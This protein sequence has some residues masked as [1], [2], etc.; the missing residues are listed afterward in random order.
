MSHDLQPDSL[1][2]FL[3]DEVDLLASLGDEA[4]K[5]ALTEG[6]TTRV[7]SPGETLVRAGDRPRGLTV[8]H[9]GLLEVS[10]PGPDGRSRRLGWRGRGDVVGEAGQAFFFPAGIPPTDA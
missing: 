10:A 3:L 4:A 8:V 2:G 6:F 7:L 1:K 5:A 9:S